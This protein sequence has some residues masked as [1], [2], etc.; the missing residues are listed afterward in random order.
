[1][2]VVE[3]TATSSLLLVLD[4]MFLFCVS[5]TLICDIHYQ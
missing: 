3:M 2:R 5:F 4:I 1:M